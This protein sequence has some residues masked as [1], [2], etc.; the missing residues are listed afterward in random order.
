VSR[1]IPTAL[2]TDIEAPVVRPFLALRIE[3]PDPVYVWTGQGTIQFADADGVTRT[4]LGAGGLGALDTVGEATDGSA[5]GIR[6]T[7]FEVPGRLQ[8]RHCSAG[9]A[10]RPDGSLHRCAERDLSAGV[11]RLRSCGRGGSTNT[12]SPTA[13][14]RFRS[15]SQARAGRSTSDGRQ[16]S[17]SRTSI[18]SATIRRPVLP[19]RCAHDRDSDP[20][21]EGRSFRGRPWRRCWLGV[22]RRQRIS[23]ERKA[24]E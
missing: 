14:R 16:L 11:K 3:L 12:R 5:T 1:P 23:R 19:V 9:R 2:E 8:G 13:A 10:R 4:W 17:G 20:V 18:S 7:L 6:A 21:G 22:Q 24:R 15:K